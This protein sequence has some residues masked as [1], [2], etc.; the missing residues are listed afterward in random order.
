M[1]AQDF[2]TQWK[3]KNAGNQAGLSTLQTDTA[4]TAENLTDSLEIKDI[5]ELEIIDISAHQIDELT[6]INWGMLQQNQTKWI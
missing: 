4:I 1:K 2:L 5:P 6:I 3:N